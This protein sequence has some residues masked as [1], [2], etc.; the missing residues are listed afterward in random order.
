[1]SVL[2]EG[3]QPEELMTRVIGGQQLYWHVLSISGGRRQIFVSGQVPRDKTGNV[4][5]KGDMAAQI[6]RVGEG[7]LDLELALGDRI[8]QEQHRRL[9]AAIGAAEADADLDRHGLFQMRDHE[10]IEHGA[11]Q[12]HDRCHRAGKQ[13][14]DVGRVSAIAGHDELFDRG[15]LGK[16]FGE[17]EVVHHLGDELPRRLTQRNLLVLAEALAFALPDPFALIRDRLHALGE[18]F[19]GK[20]RHDQRIGRRARGDGRQQHG[21]EV[22]VV[23]LID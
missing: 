14:G 4:V 9:Q 5:E 8:L 1:M 19:S 3:Y 23:K 20:Q 17:V 12:H 18:A 15:F 22:R 7:S 10:D 16:P 6:E 2:R 11:H 13:E 21:H